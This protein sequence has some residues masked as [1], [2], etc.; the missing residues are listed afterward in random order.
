MNL[1]MVNCEQDW[2]QYNIRVHLEYSTLILKNIVVLVFWWSHW[3][4]E[5]SPVLILAFLGKAV[6]DAWSKVLRA[7]HDGVCLWQ[8][9][10]DHEFKILRSVC[11]IDVLLI[12]VFS[13]SLHCQNFKIS[14]KFNVLPKQTLFVL[15]T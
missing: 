4:D 5:G 6:G 15:R 1:G 14:T 7:A 10:W 8:F 12:L 13:L 2:K 3:F 9:R 11:A